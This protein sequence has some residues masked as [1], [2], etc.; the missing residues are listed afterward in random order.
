MLFKHPSSVRN[1]AKAIL[2]QAI[3]AVSDL[4]AFNLGLVIAILLV[5]AFW[6]DLERFLPYQEMAPRFAAH[7]L[8]SLA[9]MGWFWLRLRHYSYRKPFWFELKEVLSTV[10][11]FAVI[12]LAI[13]GFSKWQLSRYVWVFTW[14]GILVLLS[15][16]RA[17]TKKLLRRLKLWQKQCVIIGTG[18]NAVDVFVALQS[19]AYLGFDIQYF[20]GC[21]DQ[22]E[23]AELLGLPVICD[24]QLLWHA[25]DAS[26]TQYVIALEYSQEKVRENW[27]K[28]LAVHK[29]QSVSVVPSTRGLPLDSTDMMFIFRREV[30]I[31][32]INNK[33]TKL[34][35]RT[36]KRGFDLISSFVLLLLCSPLLIGLA[37][38]V[39]R[40]GGKPIY[41]HL[42]VGQ[43]GK[44]F[45]CYKFRSMAVNADEILDRL[46]AADP[47][48]RAEWEQ[49]FKLKDDP[50]I[51][52]IGRFLR[53]S[54]L[55]ELPQ[56]FNVLKGEMSLIGPR[57]VVP[58]ELERY[59]DNAE[60]YL[61]VKPGMTGLWQVSGRNDVS[62]ETRV[63][64]DAWYV[65][66][67]S[68]W[69]DI[70]ILFKTIEIVFKRDGAY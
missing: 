38:L 70:T 29:C 48:A 57:P 21:A 63:Y 17:L 26:N 27:L 9:C 23:P 34:S 66:N 69:N 6:G 39:M 13:I 49:D 19:E 40:E 59:G 60:Y 54:S 68:L 35:A 55:D 53:R 30:L 16:G 12:D 43:N 1:N 32:G 44:L 20:V 14:C 47:A 11:I 41:G 24:E 3:L 56:L 2:A 15:V 51:T 45:K 5:M 25:T 37:Y 8:L 33:L 10:V 67:W 62:Y 4:L 46:L 52:R 65:K 7:G 61:M 50:R 42:R 58:E 64:F 31:L 18:S 36:L 28:Q 22:E